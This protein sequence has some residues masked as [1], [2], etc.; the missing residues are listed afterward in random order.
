M[1][2]TGKVA[3]ARVTLRSKQHLACLRVF[4]KGLV[5]ETMFYP[6]EI[7][8]MDAV[9]EKV[10]PT[11]TE[12]SMARQLIE[13][14]AKPFEPSVYRDEAREQLANLIESK[15]TGQTLMVEEPREAGKV[16][17]LME[18]LRASLAA[19]EKEK[20]KITG[21]ASSRSEEETVDS[22]TD[23]NI[24]KN[25]STLTPRKRATRKAKGA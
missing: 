19:A 16:V 1:E 24:E 4:E 11:E 25:P 23:Q 17:D 6:E 3:V 15:I 20:G 18:A 21:V 13:N 10:T 22:I 8:H 12:I 2:E 7:R 14:L 5:M 9:W